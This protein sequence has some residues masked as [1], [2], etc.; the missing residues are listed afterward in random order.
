[1]HSLLL[2]PDVLLILLLVVTVPFLIIELKHTLI[3]RKFDSFAS[4]IVEVYWVLFIKAIIY[5]VDGGR[6]VVMRW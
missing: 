3:N 2:L 1:M 4:S 6:G 5:L